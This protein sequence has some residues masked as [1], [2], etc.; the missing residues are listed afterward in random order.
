[1]R[2]RWCHDDGHYGGAVCY[3]HSKTAWQLSRRKLTEIVNRITNVTVENKLVTGASYTS[4]CSLGF[5][6]GKWK[7]SPKRRRGRRKMKDM[8]CGCLSPW[9]E[10]LSCWDRERSGVRRVDGA[11]GNRRHK[12]KKEKKQQTTTV[13][14]FRLTTQRTPSCF[15][16]FFPTFGS[17]N[18]QVA[19]GGP[20]RPLAAGGCP[21]E[22]QQ[23]RN[24]GRD[25][26]K[27]TEREITKNLME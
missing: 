3:T 11:A 26:Y 19:D 1:M 27:K 7:T 6:L 9:A 17:P 18:W 12:K 2:K 16:S 8:P 23:Q 4:L 13:V 25:Y 14:S 24:C 10:E 15:F 5:D 20:V 22:S 21:S